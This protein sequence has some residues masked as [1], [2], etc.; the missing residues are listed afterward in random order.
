MDSPGASRELDAG[1]V[2][3]VKATGSTVCGAAKVLCE[4]M[5]GA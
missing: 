1:D 2:G 3:P 4:S 5:A